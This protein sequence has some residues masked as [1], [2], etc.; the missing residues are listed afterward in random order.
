MPAH[1]GLRLTVASP[2]SKDWK[3]MK[4]TA[5]K[6]FCD[7]CRQ[8]VYDLSAMPWDEVQ[9]LL[10][11][12]QPPCVKFFQRADGTVLTA[13]CPVGRG[14]TWRALRGVVAGAALAWMA[15]LASFSAFRKKESCAAEPPFEPG[16]S[17]AALETAPP[18]PSPSSTA[19]MAQRRAQLP[20]REK[21]LTQGRP[22]TMGVIRA[23]MVPLK[24]K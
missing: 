10:D 24:S 5:Q 4:G 1:P 9:A 16:P 3:Q 21:V 11:C 12:A 7:G 15:W 2:C 23:V 20:V 13:D 6:R 14:R 8:H 19:W 18:E 22:H 17:L